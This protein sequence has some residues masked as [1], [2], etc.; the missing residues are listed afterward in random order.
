[1]K[2]DNVQ[3]VDKRKCSRVKDNIFIRYL[4]GSG[5]Y[6]RA[7]AV[8][9]DISAGGLMFETEESIIPGTELKVEIYQPI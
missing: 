3:N 4:L 7:R 9:S 8:T 2:K 5:S 1:M 6:P